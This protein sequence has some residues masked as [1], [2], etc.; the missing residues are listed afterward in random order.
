MT[1]K[2]VILHILV[3]LF[4]KRFLK[5]KLSLGLRTDNKAPGFPCP[6]SIS[7]LQSDVGSLSS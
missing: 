1:I 7:L 2:E 3:R 5:Q 4:G 6:S